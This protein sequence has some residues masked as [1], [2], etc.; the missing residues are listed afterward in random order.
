MFAT[1]L[2]T[3]FKTQNDAIK[4]RCVFKM[5]SQSNVK[6][7]H[8]NTLTAAIFN[9]KTFS[10]HNLVGLSRVRIKYSR[11]IDTP[12]P[13]YLEFIRQWF[14]C[15][16]C[17]YSFMKWAFSFVCHSMKWAKSLETTV[18]PR[19]SSCGQYHPACNKD[20]YQLH[21]STIASF[22]SN[23]HGTYRCNCTSSRTGAVS[24]F[25]IISVLYDSI[26]DQYHIIYY[27]YSVILIGRAN[28]LLCLTTSGA[29]YH[30]STYILTYG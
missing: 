15:I 13:G 23:Y 5:I 14:W 11:R 12:I 6:R 7:F 24:S 22:R 18:A 9:F 21:L 16:H 1:Y 29:L 25:M 20:N 17:K 2:I 27:I 30:T 28:W 8:S 19:I 4:L 3:V 26:I 10:A